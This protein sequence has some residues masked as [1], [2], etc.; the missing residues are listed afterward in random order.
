ML[1]RKI[2]ENGYFL[3]DVILDSIPM[4]DELPDPSYI[5]VEVPQGF[6]LPK[7]NGSEWVEGMAQSEID[8]LKN[9]PTE[10]T[11]AERLTALETAMLE[12]IMGGA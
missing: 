4:I 2:D 7:W 12:M 3:E 9:V 5:E 1:Y 6:Y 11:E 10:P 8:L